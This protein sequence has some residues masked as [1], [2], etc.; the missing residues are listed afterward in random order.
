MP[1]KNKLRGTRLE[2]RIVKMAQDFGFKARRAWGSD[3]RS[4][5]LHKDV[6]VLIDE[7]ITLQC[8]KRKK[9]PDWMGVSDDV[10]YNIIQTDYKPPMILIPF[11]EYLRMLRT[12]ETTR[13]TLKILSGKEV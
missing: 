8:K 9:L 3:G 10:D 5:G 4:M 13:T 12:I 6:D 1:S 7:R 2:N 11:E